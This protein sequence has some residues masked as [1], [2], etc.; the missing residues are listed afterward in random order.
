VVALVA[1]GGRGPEIEDALV[2]D[3]VDVVDDQGDG[4]RCDDLAVGVGVLL[5][6]AVAAEV[7]EAGRGDPVKGIVGT[8]AEVADKG[9][10]SNQ[11]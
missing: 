5:V 8:G 11:G 4:E 3:I 1:A 6:A 2:A 10:Y 9:I 7:G